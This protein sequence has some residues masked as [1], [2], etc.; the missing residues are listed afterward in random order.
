LIKRWAVPFGDVVA[1]QLEVGIVHSERR[2]DEQDWLRDLYPSPPEWIRGPRKCSPSTPADLDAFPEF[3]EYLVTSG[4]GPKYFRPVCRGPIEVKD[5]TPLTKD[6]EHLRAA[7]GDWDGEAFMNAA[8]P[9]VI[10]VFQPN[11]YYPTQ[12]A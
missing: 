6:I 4:W 11:E 3:A 1:K 7:V 2:R 9:G 8:S 5:R 10:A 12:Q